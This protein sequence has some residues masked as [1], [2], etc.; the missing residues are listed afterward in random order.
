MR[1]SDVKIG[2]KLGISFC[3]ILTLTAVVGMVAIIN[4]NSLADLTEK[5]YNHPFT[6]SN[7]AL[8]IDSNIIKINR[9]MKDVAL[10]KDKNSI[11]VAVAKIEERE[12]EVYKDFEIVTKRFLG[13][14]E[15][16]E[17]AKTL[18]TDWKPIRD[19]IINLMN[20]G[21]REKTALAVTSGGKG[22]G[23]A[24]MIE[25][26]L[27]EFIDFAQGKADFFIN[28]AKKSRFTALLQTS[29]VVAA[30]ILAGILL[31]F[32][33]TRSI[34][35]PVKQ[36]AKMAE[37]LAKGDFTQFLDINQKD[38]IGEMAASLNNAVKDLRDTIKELSDTTGTLS[39]ASEELSSVSEQMASSAE[40]MNS[41]ADMVAVSSEQV[42]TSVGTA[43]SATEQASFSVS[44]IAS[45]TEEMSSSFSNV[46]KFAKK[47]DDNVKR[48]AKS[49]EDMKTQIN[50]VASAVE[51][52]T[53]SLNE[54]AKNTAKGSRI[55][56]NASQRTEQVNTRMEALVI[57]SKK[58]GKVIGVIK[59]IADQTNM[60]ALNATIE[61]A[62][63]GEAGKGFAVVAGEVKELAK[64]SAD[65][66]GEI[67]GQVDEIQKS[68][69]DA[70]QAIEDINRV[71]SEIAAINEMIAASV[72]EQTAT[73]NEISK[74][75]ASSAMVVKNVADDA[76][77]SA[78]LVGEIARST[79]ETSKSAFEIARNI[80]EM[81][82]GVKEV[83]RSS[84]E[85]SKGVN[86]I[87]K[88]IHVISIASKQTAMSASQ[89]NESSKNLAE[90]ASVLAKIVDRFKLY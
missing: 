25:D 39:G 59:D 32:F 60:L 36:T 76:N 20:S 79:D 27:H 44:N 28:D 62:S 9:S 19:E 84:S 61:A 12:K 14:K 89:T 64:Q 7:A 1:L 18:F 41:Q 68:I 29:V 24:E 37:S 82:K 57:S 50:T 55:S 21:E 46:A 8:R 40:E 81:Q 88:N 80:D 5:L 23:Q 65:A 63:A 17:R 58:I 22:T 30:S 69:S 43:A 34:T 2:V 31:A 86:D 74:S 90:I 4:M 67:S 42:S 78:D 85:A 66:T 35:K 16:V 13:N 52:M 15:K 70:V 83:A 45:M 56:Q 54:V 51:E 71:I 75:V 73:A 11:E 87:S 3:I 77:E 47:T 48:V 6:V 33:M 53:A 26:V 49:G 72:E 38:E 10:A